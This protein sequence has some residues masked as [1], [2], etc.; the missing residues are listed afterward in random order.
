M[1]TVLTAVTA[2][3]AS[4]SAASAV[5]DRLPVTKYL[6]CATPQKLASVAWQHLVGHWCR[7]YLRTCLLADREFMHHM[8]SEAAAAAARVV[9]LSRS[10][11]NFITQHLLPSSSPVPVTVSI[12]GTTCRITQRASSCSS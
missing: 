4:M 7:V 8:E 11:A 3:A 6:Q 9:A 12:C 5:A 10:D 1:P 2:T